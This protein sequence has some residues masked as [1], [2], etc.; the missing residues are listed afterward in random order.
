MYICFVLVHMVTYVCA[1]FAYSWDLP[2][3]LVWIG[4]TSHLLLEPLHCCFLLRQTKQ[5]SVW[6]CVHVTCLHP[7]YSST[8]VPHSGQARLDGTLT[9]VRYS[10]VTSGAS[11]RM[12][13]TENC[14]TE[15]NFDHCSMAFGNTSKNPLLCQTNDKLGKT[16]G[17]WMGLAS[18]K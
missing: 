1:G 4:A 12:S 18:H 5:K 11:C 16:L 7:L 17:Y 10:G 9:S 15:V 6:H 8:R 3:I 14:H 13:S 2:G